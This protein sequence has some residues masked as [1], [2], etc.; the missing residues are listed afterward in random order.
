MYDLIRLAISKAHRNGTISFRN[1][2]EAERELQRMEE[3]GV[4]IQ[5]YRL[6]EGCVVVTVNNSDITL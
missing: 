3:D 1:A 4:C 2:V 6:E 5:S